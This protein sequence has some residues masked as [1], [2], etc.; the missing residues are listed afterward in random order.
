LHDI[1]ATP[2]PAGSDALVAARERCARELR[3]MGYAVRERPF[4]YSGFPGRLATPLLGGAGAAI[5][6]FAGKWGADGARVGPLMLL[7]LGA[8]V[9]FVAGRWL[10]VRGV[11][12]APV[13]R[14]RGVNLEAT[15]AGDTPSVWLCAHVDTKS[16]PVPTIVR[17][18]GIVLESMGYLS[19]LG[20]VVATAFGATLDQLYWQLAAIVTLVGAIPVVLSI[21]GERSPGA[22]DNASGVATVIAAARQLADER[23]I[24]ILLTDGEE[25]GL[26]GARAWARE[27]SSATVLNCDG[28]DDG[29]GVQVMFTG[30]RPEKLLDAVARASRATGVAY[31]ASRLIPGVLTDSVAFSDAGLASVT[32]SRG[33]WRSLARI[34]SRRDDLAHLQGSGI[35]ETAML[36]AATA[37]DVG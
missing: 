21:V 2:R 6:G 23:G 27:P 24:G 16:Q 28:V 10:A 34:H 30:K 7:A 13:M 36:I 33:S 1:A 5:V 29:G 37:R 15:R 25:L 11:L 12:A 18:A 26:A 9:L 35:A 31:G 19:A 8:L 14:E 3:E 20:L 22:L 32:F 17:S 4:E